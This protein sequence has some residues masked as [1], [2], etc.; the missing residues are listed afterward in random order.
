MG[1]PY[2]LDLRERVVAVVAADEPSGGGG[3]ISDQPLVNQ[4]L[5]AAGGGDG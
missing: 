5:G 1:A 2:S 4:P 3:A